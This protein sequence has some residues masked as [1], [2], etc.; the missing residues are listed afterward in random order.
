MSDVCQSSI[1][2]FSKAI[3]H[4]CHRL[5]FLDRTQPLPPPT[6]RYGR[7]C[8]A[9]IKQFRQ[10]GICPASLIRK[11]RDAPGVLPLLDVHRRR[12]TSADVRP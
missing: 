2:G 6:I 1:A 8:L 5:A 3:H 12:D 9:R 10:V 4:A 7:P 11:P